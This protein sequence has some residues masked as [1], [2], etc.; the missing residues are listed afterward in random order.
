M[1]SSVDVPVEVYSD[2][3]RSGGNETLLLGK[4]EVLLVVCSN[5]K[6]TKICVE[7]LL[8]ALVL[9]SRVRNDEEYRRLMIMMMESHGIAIHHIISSEPNEFLFRQSHYSNCIGNDDGKNECNDGVAGIETNTGTSMIYVLILRLL[10]Q[11]LHRLY[12]ILTTSMQKQQQLPVFVSTTHKS[13]IPLSCCNN[14]MQHIIHTQLQQQQPEARHQPTPIGLIYHNETLS[15]I[16]VF[17]QYLHQCGVVHKN[18]S[19]NNETTTTTT[20]GTV[21]DA[22]WKFIWHFI[23]FPMVYGIIHPKGDNTIEPDNCVNNGHP[24]AMMER[25]LYTILNETSCCTILEVGDDKNIDIQCLYKMLLQC[26]NLYF[27]ILFVQTMKVPTLSFFESALTEWLQQQHKPTSNDRHLHDD[28]QMRYHDSSQTIV[29]TTGTLKKSSLRAYILVAI[30]HKYLTFAMMIDT[31]HS[32]SD[33]HCDILSLLPWKNIQRLLLVCIVS[34]D[35]HLFDDID[36]DYVDD[37]VFSS[38]QHVHRRQKTLRSMAW[39]CLALTLKTTGLKNT[40]I[41]DFESIDVGQTNHTL[42]K[43]ITLSSSSATTTT[44]Y[45]AMKDYC[46]LLR[47]AAGEWKIQLTIIVDQCTSTVTDE[48]FS[49]TIPNLRKPAIHDN[50]CDNPLLV[51]ISSA[52]WTTISAIS[53]I[54]VATVLYLLQLS[55]SDND[56]QRHNIQ[57]SP[58]AIQ[59]IQKSLTEVHIVATQYLD[60]AKSTDRCTTNLDFV[61]R[62]VIRVFTTLT[63]DTLLF[64]PIGMNDAGR[65]SQTDSEVMGPTAIQQLDALFVAINLASAMKSDNKF[66]GDDFEVLQLVLVCVMKV[67]ASA[68]SH[69]TNISMILKS[70]IIGDVFVSFV[71][72]YLCCDDSMSCEKSAD[73]MGWLCNVIE[74]TVQ[75][76]DGNRSSTS[77]RER[78]QDAILASMRRKVEL[79]STALDAMQRAGILTKL[80]TIVDCYIGL[81]GNADPNAAE[82]IIIQQILQLIA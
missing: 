61:D 16:Q 45:G 72:T 52:D 38:P 13:E 39:S 70:N 46:T 26:I 55:E 43:S 28:K 81:L 40:W 66:Q 30:L 5:Q 20:A 58:D 74:S 35:D 79:H 10:T 34:V 27:D 24:T 50:K 53:D 68:D 64:H 54:T 63:S 73:A 49:Y 42:P 6:Q 71:T 15:C 8:V 9:L 69:A 32:A 62:C 78:Y 3:G 77:Y 33:S 44:R 11:L 1:M 75:I 22:V 57:Y 18:N 7:Q 51:V 4:I 2:D 47:L 56:K 67:L 12:D 29:G 80:Q 41:N 19:S 36:N 14:I 17:L 31:K 82:S 60:L 25:T 37:D 65:I 23:D 48:T 76:H 59:H 21:I